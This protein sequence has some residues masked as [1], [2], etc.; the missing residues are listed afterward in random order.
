METLIYI[1][2]VSLYLTLFYACY[3]LFL[4]KQT[5][6]VLNRFYLLGSLLASFL[7]PF[8][9][10][11]EQAPVLP[12]IYEATA[13]TITIT[14]TQTSNN[15]FT[16]S[17]FLWAIY[18]AGVVWMSIK[19][20]SHLRLLR[21]FLN[22]GEKVELDDC[23]VVIIN[24]NNIGSFSFLK[25]IVVNI[26]DYENHF[27]DILR[28]EMVHMQQK[29]SLDVLLV[30]A[31]KIIFWFNPILML[32]KKSLQEVHEFLADVEAS[33]RETYAR[34]LVSYTLN[35]PV[36]SLTNHFFKPSQIKSRIQMIYKNRT[37]KWLLT[38]YALTIG[39]ISIIALIIA[40]CE[41]NQPDKDVVEKTSKTETL[42]EVSREKSPEDILKGKKIF[43]VV[44]DQ[45]V[46][47]GGNKAMYEFLGDNLKYPAAASRAYVSGR[48]FLSF[49]VTETGEIADIQVL[50][51]IGFGCDEEAV[52][53]LK[54]FPK[55]TP[56]KQNGQAVNVRYNL[57]IN[58]QLKKD[59]PEAKKNFTTEED[60]PIQLNPTND[61][62][63]A[64]IQIKG[65]ALT[66]ENQP[67]YVIDGKLQKDGST[68]KAL[69]PN[70]IE[71]V[72]VLKDKHAIDQ[73]GAAGKN[74][75]IQVTTK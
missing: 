32:Y 39:S 59:E 11:P 51:G 65:D 71:S 5:F 14:A 19:F 10:Y 15:L 42:G 2:K 8:V 57:P 34:F 4:W 16:L 21:F 43:T 29:H 61:D 27:D 52:R 64:R 9:I 70:N 28:H 55:W 18:I 69:D 68:L 44:E 72:T 36:A 46:F 54:S 33:N 67:L 62:G 47:P 12:V 66:G 58:F 22:Q 53:V 37:S 25:W 41:A 73:Y 45:P 13:P 75:V 31:I 23:N 26:N 50:K 6:F 60:A 7:L 48:V 17:E 24:N 74:G 3:R 20:I 63:S 1:G 56:A 35:A 49:V 30:E 40:G 38:S